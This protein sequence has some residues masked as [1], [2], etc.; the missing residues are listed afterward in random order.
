MVLWASALDKSAFRKGVLKLPDR[1]LTCPKCHRK[2]DMRE[3]FYIRTNAECWE[4]VREMSWNR[5]R[6]RWGMIAPD[7]KDRGRDAT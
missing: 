2:R 5:S 6:A 7:G 4:C 1:F 3:W